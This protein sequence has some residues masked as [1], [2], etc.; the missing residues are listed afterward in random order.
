MVTKLKGHLK[1][2][3]T[4]HREMDSRL[5]KV[6]DSNEATTT[7]TD[8]S[9][10][11]VLMYTN[12]NFTPI[13]EHIEDLYATVVKLLSTYERLRVGIIIHTS[14]AMYPTLVWVLQPTR[15]LVQLESFLTAYK[16]NLWVQETHNFALYAAGT[17]IK[18]TSPV[19][20]V[21]MLGVSASGSRTECCREIKD[22]LAETDLHIDWRLEVDKLV[23]QQV[24]VYSCLY[25]PKKHF[26][27]I[28]FF[29]EVAK[30]TNGYYLAYK[31]E[32]PVLLEMIVKNLFGD[33]DDAYVVK[34]EELVFSKDILLGRHG[35]NQDKRQGCG[36]VRSS[37]V[38]EFNQVPA[39][40]FECHRSN[41]MKHLLGAAYGGMNYFSEDDDYYYR[42][43]D[44]YLMWYGRSGV[45][46]NE[47]E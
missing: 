39:R 33:L 7:T 19:R 15:D 23:Q 9:A 44:D 46:V 16:I 21:V 36:Y 31:R 25:A 2:T 45:Y 4:L 1:S 38:N 41:S 35:K 29:M 12:G 10:E 3:H 8:G 5:V 37:K 11:V 42:S 13:N 17:L 6:V 24:K 40:M 14:L 32:L 28:K 43:L 18:W 34:D 47:D 20:A 30:L 27:A 22:V 26:R